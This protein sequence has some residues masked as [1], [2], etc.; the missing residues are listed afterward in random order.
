VLVLAFSEFGRRVAENGSGGTDHGTAAPLLLFGGGLKGGL[1]G[2]QPSLTDLVD[3]DLKHSIDFRSVY[4][5]ILER[6][7]GADPAAI[8]GAPFDRVPFI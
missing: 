4:A 7:L 6:W 5:T 1:Y 2:Q 8:L 3:G